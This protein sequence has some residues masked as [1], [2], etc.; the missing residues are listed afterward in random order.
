MGKI[1]KGE[2]ILIFVVVALVCSVSTFFVTY[3]FVGES[4]FKEGVEAGKGQLAEAMTG[5][6]YELKI[7]GMKDGKAYEVEGSYGYSINNQP[8]VQTIPAN[9]KVGDSVVCI[10]PREGIHVLSRR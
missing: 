7:V 4:K 8:A 6:T 2:A 10:N 5:Q 3:G 9:A 1:S